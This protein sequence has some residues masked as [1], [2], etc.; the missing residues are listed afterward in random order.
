MKRK[1]YQ[2]VLSVFL[3]LLISFLQLFLFILLVIESSPADAA[4]EA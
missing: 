4:Y 1:K 3:S 2:T